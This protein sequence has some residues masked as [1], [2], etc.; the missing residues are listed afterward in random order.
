MLTGLGDRWPDRVQLSI[1][2]PMAPYDFVGNL[3]EARLT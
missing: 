2:G 3:A 1:I